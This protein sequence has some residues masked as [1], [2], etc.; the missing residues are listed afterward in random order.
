MGNVNTSLNISTNSNLENNH[1]ICIVC[2][3]KINPYHMLSCTKCNIQMHDYCYKNYNKNK[4][5]N[6]YICPRCHK[7][8]TLGK[9]LLTRECIFE[10]TIME[11]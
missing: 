6:F 4:N 9:E 5:Y 1:E 7:V 8:R 10:K 3:K 11:M 2:W